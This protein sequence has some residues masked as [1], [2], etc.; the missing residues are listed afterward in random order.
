MNKILSTLLLCL[1][2]NVTHAKTQTYTVIHGGGIDDISLTL[3][4][5]KGKEYHAYCDHKCG[6]WFDYVEETEGEM[7][8]K[9]YLDKKVQADIQYEN[10]HDRIVGPGENEKLYFIKKIQFLK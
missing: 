10:N 1:L 8:K 7:L 4:D 5:S 2:I 3:T 9:K 6:D